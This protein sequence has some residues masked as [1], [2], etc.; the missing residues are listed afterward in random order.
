M[1]AYLMSGGASKGLRQLTGHLCQLLLV[2]TFVRVIRVI[3]G[4]L[5]LLELVRLLGLLRIFKGKGYVVHTHTR[6]IYTL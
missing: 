3:M 4:W 5:G 6:S 2:S 1:N